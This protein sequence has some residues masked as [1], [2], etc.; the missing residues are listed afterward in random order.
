MFKRFKPYC[1]LS[2]LAW[3]LISCTPAPS[4]PTNTPE[5]SGVGEN[6]IKGYELYSWEINSRVWAY[7]LLPGTNALKTHN[8]ISAQQQTQPQIVSS[9][10]ALPLGTEVFWNPSHST[11]GSTT[12]KFGLPDD[13]LTAELRQVIQERELKISTPNS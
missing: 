11:Q 3:V 8:T 9:L 6:A 1:Q 7:A 10:R 5:T 13:S 12:L 4:S 2:L